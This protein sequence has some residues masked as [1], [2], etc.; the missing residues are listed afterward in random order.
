MYTKRKPNP[1]EYECDYCGH[2]D[3]KRVTGT[4]T[5]CDPCREE[6][7]SAKPTDANYA[8]LTT[9]LI[10]TDKEALGLL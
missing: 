9:G 5:M 3:A 8:Y 7:T 4:L 10:A 6:V 1:G 2:R